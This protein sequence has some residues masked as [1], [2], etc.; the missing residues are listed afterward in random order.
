M[1]DAI[2]VT[3]INSDS[4]PYWMDTVDLLFAPEGYDYSSRYQWKW[5]NEGVD[6]R[7]LKGQRALLIFL[8]TSKG[9]DYYLPLREAIVTE[10]SDHGPFVVI[11]YRLGRF[12]DLT[13]SPHDYSIQFDLQLRRMMDAGN[14]AVG[15]AGHLVFPLQNIDVRFSTKEVDDDHNWANMVNEVVRSKI[16]SESVFL[17]FH[18]LVEDE[19]GEA[20]TMKEGQFLLKSGRVYRMDIV[21]YLPTLDG[22]NNSI[23]RSRTTDLGKIELE[24]MEIHMDALENEL[25][26]VGRYDDHTFFF[27]AKRVTDKTYSRIAVLGKGADSFYIPLLTLQVQIAP[28]RFVFIGYA[29]FLAG[30]IIIGLSTLIPG[31]E[32]ILAAGGSVISTAGL[33]FLER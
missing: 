29:G 27:V 10:V 8:G 19:S 26:V 25:E 15:H 11:R 30:L 28:Y 2:S 12:V 22:G 32:I 6:P 23:E 1:E 9:E 20:L 21:Q 7:G 13:S 24:T 5:V 16:F 17:R 14:V 3:L 31:A 18:R 33:L 4:R